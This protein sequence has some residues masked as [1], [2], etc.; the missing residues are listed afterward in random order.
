MF[1]TDKILLT[2]LLTYKMYLHFQIKSFKLIWRH[3][4]NN[5][6][7]AENVQMVCMRKKN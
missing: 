1:L 6:Y 2:M 7:N 4:L 5:G 3:F